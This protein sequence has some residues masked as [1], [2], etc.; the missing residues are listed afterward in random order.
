[1][2]KTILHISKFRVPIHKLHKLFDAHLWSGVNHI[3][4]LS[5]LIL[6][7]S[8]KFDLLKIVNQMISQ[9]IVSHSSYIMSYTPQLIT[10]RTICPLTPRI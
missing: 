7:S 1:M 8:V 6:F 3:Y 10:P 9:H 2:Q 4:V 5:G